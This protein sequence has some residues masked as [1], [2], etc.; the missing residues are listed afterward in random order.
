MTQS[1]LFRKD[2]GFQISNKQKIDFFAKFCP[3]CTLKSRILWKIAF[4]TEWHIWCNI[5][6]SK[7]KKR[8]E[9]WSLCQVFY[10]IKLCCS[11]SLTFDPSFK[12]KKKKKSFIRQ[13]TEWASFSGSLRSNGCSLSSNGLETWFDAH[14]RTSRATLFALKEKEPRVLL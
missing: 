14:D 13:R 9:M 11:T 6:I 1:A 12:S 5:S 2:W 10:M 3:T 8:C 4:D 7:K